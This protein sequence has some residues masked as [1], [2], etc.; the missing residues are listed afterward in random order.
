MTPAQAEVTERLG[1]GTLAAHA[2][3]PRRE[4]PGSPCGASVTLT[5]VPLQARQPPPRWFP[6]P[7]P[8]STVFSGKQGD[9]CR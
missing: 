2:S 5:L 7:C 8:L 9:P 3:G 4:G 6:L 1:L